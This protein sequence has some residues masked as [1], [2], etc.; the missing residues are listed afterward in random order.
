M[1][2]VTAGPPLVL[3]SA[4]PRR[5]ELLGRMG[6]TFDVSPTDVDE[7]PLDGEA[8][9]ELVARLAEAKARRAL[10]D[11]GREGGV[12]A[13]PSSLP[14]VLAADTIVVLDDR[15]IG[16]PRDPA[17]AVAMLRSLSGRTHLVIS[18]VAVARVDRVLDE[19]RV[20][21]VVE[22]TQVT[23]AEVGDAE[24]AAYV[25][26]G[27]PMDKAG[28]YGI[29]GRGGNL[30]TRIEGSYDNVVGLP[31]HRVAQILGLR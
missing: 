12:A 1:N 26:T 24:I 8:P 22:S 2:P 5:R 3:A 10:A 11:L 23:F 28:A 19:P 31:I 9:E 20:E 6:L 27:E 21:V 15:I 14:V 17:D 16:K 29:Q 18:G 7:T 30:V 4:S 13:D 25:A